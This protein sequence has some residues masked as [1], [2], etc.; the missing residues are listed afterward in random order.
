[1][2][3]RLTQAMFGSRSVSKSLVLPTYHGSGTLS[4]VFTGMKYPELSIPMYQVGLTLKARRIAALTMF[5][6]T[7]D[8]PEAGREPLPMWLQRP[9]PFDNLLTHHLMQQLVTGQE[10]DGDFFI[11]TP[12]NEKTLEIQALIP[13][14]WELVNPVYGPTTTFYEVMGEDES[15]PLSILNILH[16]RDRLISTSP[17]GNSPTKLARST[18]E[19]RERI[20]RLSAEM[21]D[22]GF[23]AYGIVEFANSE[24]NSQQL[25]MFYRMFNQEF[26]GVQGAGKVAAVIGGTYRPVPFQADNA[27]LIEQRIHMAREAGKLSG[28]PGVVM[29]DNNG[30]TM[31]GTGLAQL[32]QGWIAFDLAPSIKN[33]EE[34]LNWACWSEGRDIK[35]KFDLDELQRTDIWQVRADLRLMVASGIMTTNEA[36]EILKMVRSD[37]P[38]A[39]KLLRPNY[40]LSS[41]EVLAKQVA[42]LE[43]KDIPASDL[44]DD[45]DTIREALRPEA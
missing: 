23:S 26:G 27:Q 30:A 40:Q 32:I 39:D 11:Y 43:A 3:S 45:M 1:M 9:K 25:K 24:A 14:P 22:K 6:Y 21:A 33:V 37:D 17:A 31:W 8:D 42:E 28:T 10:L 35:I 36:R 41:D 15:L 2:A 13:I 29:G 16:F 20:E 7:D 5:A 12:R 18:I 34:T 19:N 4:S 44:L 38:A